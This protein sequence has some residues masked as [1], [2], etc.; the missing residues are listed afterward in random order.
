MFSLISSRHD[1]HG[2]RSHPTSCLFTCVPL[3]QI[4]AISTNAT[5][6][7]LPA[8]VP[9]LPQA[10]VQMCSAHWDVPNISPQLKLSAS[11]LLPA[12][13]LL[14][15]FSCVRLCATPKTA[16]HQAPPSLGFSRQ[17]HW[18][19]LPFPSPI[20]ESEKWEWSRSVVSD[21]QRPHGLQPTRLLRPWDFPG[22]ST[23]V[24][25]PGDHLL[26]SHS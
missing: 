26:S 4:P 25:C 10:L 11:W 18:S 9:F 6:Q 1:L 5:P 2:I 24:G 20:H 3:P 22:K 12:A 7:F 16:A 8:S 15:H 21:P 13:C 23:G 19:G 17:E 14:S